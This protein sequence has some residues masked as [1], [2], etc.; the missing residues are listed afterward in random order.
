MS[1]IKYLYDPFTPVFP[2][3]IKATKRQKYEFETR[4][5]A[6]VR[7]VKIYSYEVWLP[8]GVG[9]NPST[10][11]L[12][13]KKTR[14][15]E[16]I[17]YEK[18]LVHATTSKED[19][20]KLIIKLVNSLFTLNDSLPQKA[21][22]N[23]VNYS[24]CFKV[25]KKPT[26]SP[27]LSVVANISGQKPN[28]RNIA[29]SSLGGVDDALQ[30][31]AWM[32]DQLDD[33]SMSLELGNSAPFNYDRSKEIVTSL[34]S[35]NKAIYTSQLKTAFERYAEN[36]DLQI[37]AQDK[38][39]NASWG[40][41]APFIDA[42]NNSI[43]Q[44]RQ[45]K[46]VENNDEI[47]TEN[48]HTHPHKTSG[49][50]GVLV[51]LARREL[52]LQISAII[53]KTSS[54]SF[55]IKRF[56]LSK[57]T[58]KEAFELAKKAY[59]DAFSLSH[60]TTYQMNREYE[61]FKGA[62]VRTLPSKLLYQTGRA[63]EGVQVVKQPKPVRMI[64]LSKEEITKLKAKKA[65]AEGKIKKAK[66][67]KKVA[68]PIKIKDVISDLP[69][70][71][72]DE[73]AT[74]IETKE[75][76]LDCGIAATVEE[77]VPNIDELM[78]EAELLIKERHQLRS[79]HSHALDVL[80]DGEFGFTNFGDLPPTQDIQLA[81]CQNCSSPAI[82]TEEKGMYCCHCTKCTKQGALVPSLWRASLDWN[83]LN[84]LSMKVTDIPHFHLYGRSIETSYLYLENIEPLIAVQDELC[85]VETELALLQRRYKLQL[86]RKYQK[87]GKS[88]KESIEAYR[89]WFNITFE[90]VK[91]YR[92]V[93][94][95]WNK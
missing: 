55:Q 16:Q 74:S 79:K 8:K 80:R 43:T 26:H 12:Y 71:E 41:L 15:S 68:K 28:I 33:Y 19:V 50:V 53:G 69:D 6:P 52:N 17:L 91:R 36:V 27:T 35:S 25:P 32:H 21:S 70:V 14:N 23:T 90:V 20:A 1:K 73:V 47:K 95:A 88:F 38:S 5:K 85:Q 83:S 42:V 76:D 62:L 66:T 30:L 57:Y 86:G 31:I 61:L 75:T 59:L 13:A 77:P 60:P 92:L 81:D 51:S 54:G 48:F 72:I 9:F 56:T 67:K 63:L 78:A 2:S 34:T 58:L 94:R 89:Y 18:G 84:T 93:G 10:K 4:L 45:I 46:I 37:E 29:L 24:V 7:K 64:E 40:Q 44:A 87:P 22:A 3:L 49:V 82:V 39:E 65:K 11:E